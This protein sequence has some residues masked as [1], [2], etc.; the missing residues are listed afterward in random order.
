MFAALTEIPHVRCMRHDDDFQSF[1]PNLL[2]KPKRIVQ[3][4][5]GYREQLDEVVPTFSRIGQYRFFFC[6]YDPGEGMHIHVIR[7]KEEAWFW[8]EPVS[9][10]KNQGMSPLEIQ[11]AL[12]LMTE[13]KEIIADEWKKRTGC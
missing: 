12:K 3:Y 13:N 2:E 8:L 1:I 11:T 4:G 10:A 9:L 6:S 7:E 5:S